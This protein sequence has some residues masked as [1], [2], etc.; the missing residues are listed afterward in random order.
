MIIYRAIAHI[1][2]N[3]Y[4]FIAQNG[5]D[6]TNI[7]VKSYDLDIYD[8]ANHH[9]NLHTLSSENPISTLPIVEDSMFAAN[10]G[11][12]RWVTEGHT[13]YIVK[14][15]V[16]RGDSKNDQQ[17]ENMYMQIHVDEGFDTAHITALDT[18]PVIHTFGDNVIAYYWHNE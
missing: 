15:S 13:D 2:N 7:E 5:N 18:T 12:K 8:Q 9:F 3:G 4:E 11:I 16:P 1:H 17:P 10:I 6:N 14:L